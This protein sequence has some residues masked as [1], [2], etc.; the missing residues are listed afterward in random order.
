MR[1]ECLSGLRIAYEKLAV[2]TYFARLVEVDADCQGFRQEKL[3]HG[4]N[5]SGC[6]E[7]ANA[8]IKEGSTGHVVKKYARVLYRRLTS[9][10]MN[11]FDIRTMI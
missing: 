9:L 4:A 2:T 7:P 8:V 5:E 3:R 6:R 11:S 10:I 1:G